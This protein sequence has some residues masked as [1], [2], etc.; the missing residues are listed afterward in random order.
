MYRHLTR[1]ELY[2]LIKAEPLNA[3][4]MRE[5]AKRFIAHMERNGRNSRR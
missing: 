3:E 4:A 5:I 2:R 1:E